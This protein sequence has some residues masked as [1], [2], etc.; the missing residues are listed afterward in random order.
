ML[1]NLK[2]DTYNIVLSPKADKFLKKIAKKNKKDFKNL[3]NVIETISKNP[4]YSIKLKNTNNK[5]RRIR[6]GDYRIK[7]IINNDNVEITMIGKRSNIYNKLL[8]SI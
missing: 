2:K 1:I 7:F 6:K 5:E 3:V 8:I 4:Y